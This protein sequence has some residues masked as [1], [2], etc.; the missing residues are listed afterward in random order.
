MAHSRREIFANNLHLEARNVREQSAHSRQEMFKNNLH[1]EA[2]NVREQF[3]PS[4]HG[5]NG[6]LCTPR[7]RAFSDARPEVP[8]QWSAG[9][10]LFTPTEAFGTTLMHA[11]WCKYRGLEAYITQRS[12]PPIDRCQFPNPVVR[13]ELGKMYALRGNRTPGGSTL[14]AVWWQRPRL[15]LP[16]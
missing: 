11:W 12:K 3:A 15:P 1:L 2:R 7:M 13:G 6:L 9:H 4:R 10:N 14:R 16:H 8:N 5:M